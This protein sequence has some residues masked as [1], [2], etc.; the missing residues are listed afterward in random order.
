MVFSSMERAACGPLSFSGRLFFGCAP[1]FLA[2]GL[3]GLSAFPVS[4]DASRRYYVGP[5]GKPVFLMG[6]YSWAAL[7]D[8]EFIDHGTRYHE[9][10]DLDQPYGLNYIRMSLGINRF[11]STTNPPVWSGQPNSVPFVYV[12]GKADLDQWDG[13]F[14]NGL[15]EQVEYAAAR[16]FIVHVGIF[17][18]YDMTAG[19]E[20]YKWN[21]S[22]WNHDNQVRDFFG[23][24]DTD[25]DGT[26]DEMGD[27]WR[28]ADFN[29]KTGVGKYQRMLIDKAV[30]EVGSYD[31]VMFELGNETFGADAGI[32]NAM[33][34]YF[35]TRT[36]RLMTVNAIEIVTLTD[37]AGDG[38]SEHPANT[39]AEVKQRIG[40][41][42]GKGWPAWEDPDGSLLATGSPDNL[43][44]CAW[45]SLA[46]GAAGWGGYSYDWTDTP[47]MNTS[48]VD[49][50]QK[51]LAFLKTSGLRFW[52]MEPRH[53]LAGNPS[54]NSCLADE[55]R[56]YLLYV[57]DDT[58]ETLDLSQLSGQANYRLYDPGTG[59]FGASATVNGGG[60]RTF[61]RPPGAD[62]WAVHI[63][64]NTNNF[65]IWNSKQPWNSQESSMT[66]DPDSDGIG[67]LLEYALDL[68][69]L[70]PDPRAS[71]PQLALDEVT[72]D[73]PWF[74][75][76]YRKNLF[77][78]DL[79]IG[80]S[81]STDLYS[82]ESLVPDGS[83]V[84]EDADADGD[85]TAA[86]IR[87]RLKM[88]SAEARRFLRLHASAST[89]TYSVWSGQQ[90]WN[91]ADASIY[92]NTDADLFNNLLE[93]AFDLSPIVSDAPS[94]GPVAGTNTTTPGGPWTT[95]TYRKNS[96]AHDITHTL[97]ASTDLVHWTD[98][99]IDR[100]NAFAEV[101]DPGPDGD[102]SSSLVRLRVK[103]DPAV[104]R[105][106]LSL[107][108][109]Q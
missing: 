94:K 24:L 8:G 55:G 77:A 59:V 48:K 93:Y 34:D 95:F 45:Y 9:I 39:P 58:S 41:F 78:T 52:N 18:G 91:G 75:F 7:A 104:P 46:G 10:M 2:L 5:H 102:G 13:T 105:R 83:A 76:T 30:A 22:F 21:N 108:V 38:A 56:E 74:H 69:P 57:L 35:R 97:R 109:S 70:T 54:R 19:P 4:L 44:R 66:G 23:D 36:T 50:Y 53:D 1:T 29:N 62:D 28:T 90:A 86:L 80:V 47:S 27:F 20:S 79:S 6:Y 51:L 43:R 67:T 12:D 88:N 26:A 71:L 49:Y 42:V 61:S 72:P 101:A 65:V 17:D 32:R 100:V 89:G 98:I 68:D 11:T 40:Q 85:G 73:G 37:G 96:T 103:Q 15:R 33:I 60:V 82:W 25:G 87:L 107:K 16:G 63:V 92:G 106:F 31:N 84:I 64:K 99:K 14:W 81:T 3:G